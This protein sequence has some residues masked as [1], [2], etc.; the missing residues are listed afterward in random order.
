MHSSETKIAIKNIYVSFIANFFSLLITFLVT[1]L[2]N[3]FVG[4]A[5]FGLF[6]IGISLVPYVTLFLSSIDILSIFRLYE[7]L[8]KKN[9][10][11][12]NKLMSRSLYEYRTRGCLSF[13]G[14][15]IIS[16]IFPFIFGSNGTYDGLLNG[17]IIF[18]GGLSSMFSFVFS[19]IY[20]KV[21]IVE[22]KGYILQIFDL[23][24]KIIFN[25][26]F[27]SIIITN[28]FF[29]Y[30]ENE[31]LKW[32]IVISAFVTNSTNS[33]GILIAFNLRK[34][35]CPWFFGKMYKKDV[36]DSKIRKFIILDSIIAQF[37][38][39][40]TYFTFA[41]YNNFNAN[42]QLL[43]GIYG[44]YFLVKQAVS[45]LLTI[46][47]NS[48]SSS[49]ARIYYSSSS[50]FYQ[51]AYKIYDYFSFVIALLAFFI[52][53]IFSPFFATFNTTN[54]FELKNGNINN[55]IQTFNIWI[56]FLIS[57]SCFIE[58]SRNAS[59]NLKNIQGQYLWK[60]KFAIGEA[61]INVSFTI[62]GIT[63][64]SIFPWLN[65]LGVIAS[66]LIANILATGFRYISIKISILK[67]FFQY[68]KNIKIILFLRTIFLESF[69]V[70]ILGL[71]FSLFINYYFS[72]TLVLN[73]SWNTVLIFFII[74]IITLFL[75]IFIFLISI[76]FNKELRI[77]LFNYFK[78]SFM[79][80][81]KKNF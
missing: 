19:P 25:S 67:N 15:L 64:S 9:Y 31:N 37:V 44:N 69:F 2:M 40:T 66:L 72:S 42:A 17:L 27:I 28:Y 50:F 5:N 73:L 60:F 22:R 34:K 62:L 33:F 10:D 29:K 8:S 20:Q 47:L 12:A 1:Y 52:T 54:S 21:L 49:L 13:I 63:I 53:L 41:I 3:Q 7:P 65:G 78:N 51:K 71:F 74:G 4:T 80:N 18:M 77:F 43:A 58:V 16:I 48:T 26:I 45:Y 81:K 56:S 46:V 11:L 35:I 68:K 23:L 38:I 70:L 14:L 57:L 36:G 76:S 61:I 59:E 75:I 6:S 79:K 30:F 55:G 24:G 32:I 39:N